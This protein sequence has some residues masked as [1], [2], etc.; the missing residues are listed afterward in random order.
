MKKLLF[1]IVGFMGL[2]LLAGCSSD[3]L[4]EYLEASEK[5]NTI[6]KGNTKMSLR[7]DLDFE[8]EGLSD[9]QMRELSYF[10][11]IDIESNTQF[12]SSDE[13]EKVISKTYF[14]FGGVGF[15]SVFYMNGEQMFIQM[16]I[17]KDY[18]RLDSFF[19]S[20]LDNNEEGS[21]SSSEDLLRPFYERWMEILG[22]EDVVKGKKTYVLT[23][24][25]QIKASTYSIS[26]SKEQLKDLSNE[27]L[28]VLKD[29]RFFELVQKGAYYEGD[30]NEAQ[31][32]DLIE[33]YTN[34][35]TLEGFE[36]NVYVDFDGLIVKKG[37]H[38]SLGMND[39][40]VGE[41]KGIDLSFELEYANLGE[42]QVFQ[43]PTVKEDEWLKVEDA[44]IESLLPEGLLNEWGE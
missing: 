18:I 44:N 33:E 34:R 30:L 2:S 31:M 36:G 25:G 26:I 43:F 29:K 6:E 41:L 21:F 5:T 19:D 22:E 23:D 32:L 8:T 35:V 15:D 24:E 12:D 37:Y 39:T 38:L 4:S 28:K 42:E 14:N 17:I 1:L 40:K 16:P 9:K 20:Y 13:M 27:M 3:S 7:A 10:D 11:Q